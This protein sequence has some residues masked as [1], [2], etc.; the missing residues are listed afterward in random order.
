M[1]QSLFLGTLQSAEGFPR[2]PRL[3]SSLST[4]SRCLADGNM[5]SEME[6]NQK[7]RT[8]SGLIALGQPSVVSLLHS[9]VSD[10][11]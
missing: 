6:L 1:D 11:R 8:D 3:E 7:C 5:L 10:H 9:D 4:F 2:D